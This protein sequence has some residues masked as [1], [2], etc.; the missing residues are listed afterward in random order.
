MMKSYYISL[1]YSFAIAAVLG[2]AFLLCGEPFLYI[3]TNDADVVAAGME[4]M[5]IMCFL[6]R[7]RLHGL[8]HRCAAAALAAALCRR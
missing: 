3:F 1:G 2:A 6:L 7:Q 4:R 5:R 8:H